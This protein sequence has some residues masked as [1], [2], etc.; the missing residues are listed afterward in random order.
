MAV[1]VAVGV[2]VGVEVAVGVAVAVGL[3]VG[4]GVG[5]A[6]ATNSVIDDAT[7]PGAVIPRTSHIHRSV[8]WC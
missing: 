6:V 7:G 5:E 2:E 4:V 1:G 3:T 8:F